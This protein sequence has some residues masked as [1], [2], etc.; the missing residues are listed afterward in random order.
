MR[1]Q[2]SR[3]NY[4]LLFDVAISVGRGLS[5]RHQNA[6]GKART[7]DCFVRLGEDLLIL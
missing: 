3:L 7:S 2:A 1:A 6:F 4:F 5:R